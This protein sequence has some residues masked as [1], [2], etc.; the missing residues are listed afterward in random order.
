VS[1]VLSSCHSVCK[2][3]FV[4]LFDLSCS[5]SLGLCVYLSVSIPLTVYLSLIV[6]VHIPL[7]AF[8]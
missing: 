7:F 3:F 8:V 1:A 4:S 5:I 6:T 2:P